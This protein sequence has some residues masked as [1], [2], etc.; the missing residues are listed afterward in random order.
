MRGFNSGEH[1]V[2][3]LAEPL[4]VSLVVTFSQFFHTWGGGLRLGALGEH[5]LE[6]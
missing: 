4:A 3:F 6:M 1:F 5:A 2:L